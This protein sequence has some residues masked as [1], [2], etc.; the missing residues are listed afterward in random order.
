MFVHAA[1][2]VALAIFSKHFVRAAAAIVKRL[3]T[4]LNATTAM[5]RDAL[6]LD[7]PGA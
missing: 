1:I 2:V 4:C 3:C 7:V 5:V 6:R